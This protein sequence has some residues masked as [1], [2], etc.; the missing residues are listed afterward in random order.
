MD[1]HAADG[2]GSCVSLSL[3][4]QAKELTVMPE[5][6]SECDIDFNIGIIVLEKRVPIDDSIMP[7]CIDWRGS[8]NPN[9]DEYGVVS[10]D[11]IFLYQ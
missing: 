2:K 6:C 4:L 1:G 3:F 7:A 11:L 5:R 9:H 8:M 10:V